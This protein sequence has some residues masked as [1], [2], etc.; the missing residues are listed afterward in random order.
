ML[1]EGA[2]CIL[3]ALKLGPNQSCPWRVDGHLLPMEVLP[4]WILA[5]H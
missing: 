2:S 5:D 4:L 3:N 1:D